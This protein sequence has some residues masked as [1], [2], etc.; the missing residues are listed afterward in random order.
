MAPAPKAQRAPKGAIVHDPDGPVINEDTLL[1]TQ[2][3][4]IQYE[5]TQRNKLDQIA[6][7][8]STPANF[9]S[10][11]KT[12]F[13]RR[14][15]S[16][17]DGRATTP[18][19]VRGNTMDM[20]EHLKH[21]GPSNLASRPKST[22][23]NA[24][25]IK[26]G[27]TT[28]PSDSNARPPSVVEEPY[29]DIPASGGGEGAGLL[30]SAGREASDGVQAVQQGYGSMDRT[31]N[32]SKTLE[33][34][35]AAAHETPDSPLGQSDRNI[36]PLRPSVRRGPSSNSQR[37]S[38]TLGSLRSRSDSPPRK[39]GIARSG[40]ITENIVD[41]GGVRKVV[42]ETTSSSDDIDKDGAHPSG[43]HSS[44]NQSSQSLLSTQENDKPKT[45]THNGDGHG[46]EV[47][48]KR[49]RRNKK[50]GAMKGEDSVVASSST[51]H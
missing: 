17:A 25:K 1:E 24:V 26:P 21:L 20:R 33:A 5:E 43:K 2:D 4:L 15:S 13:L 46:E 51:Q 19:P 34:N 42:L 22:R 39:R 12:T 16:A 41:T 35:K 7:K 6:S 8:A 27:H 29:R 30:R 50:K 9:G 14:S 32:F 3:D 47:K 31:S 11:P 23:Y 36:S 44:H 10:S 45:S 40:S 28:M 49:K 38:D 48:K 18:V 37:S